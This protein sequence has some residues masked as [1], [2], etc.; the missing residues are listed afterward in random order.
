MNPTTLHTLPMPAHC[1]RT[2]MVSASVLA[3]NLFGP[4]YSGVGI[5]Q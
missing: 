5:P 2:G 4:D 3:S 1:A